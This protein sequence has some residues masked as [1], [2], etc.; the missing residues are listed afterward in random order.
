MNVVRKKEILLEVLE[1]QGRIDGLTA[2]DIKR[3]FDQAISDGLHDLVVDFH[4][5]TY[6][7]SAGLRVILQTHKNLKIIG[8]ALLLVAVPPAVVDVFRVSG[9]E[10]FLTIFPDLVSIRRYLNKE[11]HEETSQKIEIDGLTFQWLKGTDDSGKFFPV[12][13][14]AKL[15]SSTY[16]PE[17]VIRVDQLEIEYGAGLAVVGNDYEEYR[18]LFGESVFLHHH[19]FSFPAVRRPVVDYSFYTSGSDQKINFLHGF[20]MSGDF[21]GILHFETTDQAPTLQQLVVAAGKMTKSGVFGVVILAKSAGIFGM[22]LKRSPVEPKRPA[23]GSIFD[24]EVFHNWMS[25]SLE[26]EDIHETVAATGIVMN[27][28][29]LAGAGWN[30]FFPVGSSLHIHAV[31]LANGLWSNQPVVFEKELERVIREFEVL[32]VIHLLPASRLLNG[33]VGII[34]LEG[35]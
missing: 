18:S 32:K 1:V 9:M 26:E 10:A 5:V 23:K 16:G 14:P 8:G 20:G 13:S 24:K 7:S 34:N 17:D 21:A 6:L 2:P 33:F 15:D 11:I 30:K 31:L 3:A 29:E 12:G 35:V 28:P 19:F 4:G 22:H 27:H 25:Y